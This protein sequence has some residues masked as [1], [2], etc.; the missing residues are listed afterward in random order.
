V[1][2][3]LLDEHRNLQTNL[4]DMTSERDDA[5]TKLREARNEIDD[6]GRNERSDAHLRAEIERL[7]VELQKSEDNLGMAELELDKNTTLV[8][9]LTRKVDE[10]QEKADLAAR[11]KDQ[12]DEYVQSF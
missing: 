5:L 3:T 6:L 9:D 11:L 12:V 2:Q 7:R 10:L 8:T 1:H 4:D